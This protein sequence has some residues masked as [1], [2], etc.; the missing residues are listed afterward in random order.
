MFL[1]Q[2]SP[3][4]SDGLNTSTLLL[5][6]LQLEMSLNLDVSVKVSFGASQALS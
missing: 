4:G 6:Q 1:L 5:H 2:T 3:H